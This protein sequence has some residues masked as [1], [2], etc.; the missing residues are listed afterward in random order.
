MN[1]TH[2]D[3]AKTKKESN[4]PKGN[5]RV[6]FFKVG[7]VFSSSSHSPSSPPPKRSSKVLF[8]FEGGPSTKDHT[9]HRTHARCVCVCVPSG[10]FFVITRANTQQTTEPAVAVPSKTGAS[11][12][13]ET[14]FSAH[15]TKYSRF[16][17]RKECPC[18]QKNWM[19]SDPVL[20][21]CDWVCEEGEKS[22]EWRNE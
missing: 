18:K 15:F 16:L 5:G 12:E 21:Q 17:S 3:D 13:E 6:S 14:R 11:T 7:G 9:G 22:G 10:F 1:H 19:P 2:F 8:F 20:L 4:I